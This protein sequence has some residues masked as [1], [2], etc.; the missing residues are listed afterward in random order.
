MGG[1]NIRCGTFEGEDKSGSPIHA[2]LSEAFKRA[3]G[4]TP[5]GR[6]ALAF[7]RI[8]GLHQADIASVAESALLTVKYD[9]IGRLPA[10]VSAHLLPYLKEY[11]AEILTRLGI[12][13][14]AEEIRARIKRSTGA[15]YGLTR[16]DGWHA[17]CLRDLI[18]ACEQ[19]KVHGD[20]IEI[21][22]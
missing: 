16:D 21:A 15:K 9:A 6:I 12:S 10:E 20:P 19:S 11:Y 8:L 18:T 4:R 3:F 2:V 14:T 13:G 1:A 17:Y 22:W 7:A 5:R